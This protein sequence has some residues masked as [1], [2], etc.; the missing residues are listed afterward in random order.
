MAALGAPG[1]LGMDATTIIRADLVGCPVGEC[2]G[3]KIWRDCSA[4]GGT[5]IFGGGE[6]ERGHGGIG[7]DCGRCKAEG[8]LIVRECELCAGTSHVRRPLADLYEADRFCRRNDPAWT[9]I[10][11]DGHRGIT[12]YSQAMWYR[13]RAGFGPIVRAAG[14][15]TGDGSDAGPTVVLENA[16]GAKL[17][18]HGF[19]WGYGGEGPNGLADV[20]SDVFPGK[21]PRKDDAL[22]VVAAFDFNGSWEIGAAAPTAAPDAEVA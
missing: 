4:C 20:L 15:F 2:F 12:L 17:T 16:G 7:E 13:T 19:A 21:F 3:G 1:A 8:Q 10:D 18:L 6:D 11:H 14:A 5:G 9:G 22:A